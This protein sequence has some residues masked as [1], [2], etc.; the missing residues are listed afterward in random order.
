V[1][2]SVNIGFWSSP[3]AMHKIVLFGSI[4]FSVNKVLTLGAFGDSS[5]SLSSSEDVSLSSLFSFVLLLAAS[6]VVD[7][8]EVPKSFNH[9][10]SIFILCS[11]YKLLLLSRYCNA[12]IIL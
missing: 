11:L 9:S 8:S 2:S 7:V 12:S 10:G 5:F 3:G 6:G 1:S 4:V